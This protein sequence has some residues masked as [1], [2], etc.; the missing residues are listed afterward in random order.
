MVLAAAVVAASVVALAMWRRP[1]PPGMMQDIQAG[2]AARNIPDADQRIAR[3]LELRYGPLT[4]PENREKAFL[5]F[6]NK[7]HID[8]LHL[9]VKHSPAH[10]RQ[11]NVDAMAK[12]VEGYRKSMTD[13]ERRTLN[14]KFST[15]QGASMLHQATARYNSQDV[16]YRSATAPVISQL[17]RTIS[18]VQNP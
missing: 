9:M 11:A 16:Q 4:N 6:F 17:L 3:Y 1:L 13:D 10:Q 5:D 18:S 2:I 8:A 7:D 12:W 14:A 15:P